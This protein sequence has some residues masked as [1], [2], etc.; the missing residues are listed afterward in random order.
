MNKEITWAIRANPFVLLIY[1]YLQP[2]F[3]YLTS[4][5][6]LS[7][8]IRRGY[9][10]PD[11]WISCVMYEEIVQEVHEFLVLIKLAIK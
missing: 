8:L 7:D 3:T 6:T 11:I 4:S 5:S 1:G 10:A 2:G 9:V